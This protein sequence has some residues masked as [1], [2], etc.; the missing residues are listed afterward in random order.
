M[1]TWNK[2]N[3]SI[4]TSDERSALGLIEELGKQTNYNTE[5]VEKVKESNNKKVSHDEMHNLYKIDDQADFTGSWHGL[6]YPTLSDVGLKAKV[7]EIDT[8]VKEFNKHIWSMENMGQDVKEAMTGGSVAVV[9][10]NA[11]THVNI[12]DGEVYGE[13]TNFLNQL[14]K[15]M[16]KGEFLDYYLSGNDERMKLTKSDT[17]KLVALDIKGNTQYSINKTVV[18]IEG[19]DYYFKIATFTKSVEDVLKLLNSGDVYVDG[20]ILKTLTSTT[21]EHLNYKF[22]SGANDKSVFILVA[23]EKEPYTEVIQGNVTGL[24]YDSYDGIYEA[25]ANVFFKGENIKDKTIDIEKM[26]YYETANKNLFDGNFLNFYVSGKNSTGLMVLIQSD[27]YKTLIFDVEPNTEYTLLKDP[28]ESEDGYYYTKLASFIIPKEQ[29]IK[30]NNYTQDGSLGLSYTSSDVTRLV[31]TTGPND[32]SVAITVAKSQIPY[33]EVLKGNYSSYQ[34]FGYT[35]KY[36]SPSLDYYTKDEVNRK[37][38]DLKLNRFIKTGNQMTITMGDSLYIFE[39]KTTSSN[40]LDTYR[41]TKG[42]HKDVLIWEGSDIEA[43]ILEKGASDFVGGVHGYEQYLD[44]NILVDGVKIGNSLDVDVN[45][46]NLTIFVKSYLYRHG[47]TTPVFTRYKKLEFK[48]NELIVSNNMICMVE[49]FI[50]TRYTGSGLYS[51]YK[52]IVNGYTLN[53]LHR[54]VTEGGQTKSNKI[55]E[56]QFFCNGFTI[57]VKAIDGIGEN[58][59]GSVADF[60]SESKPRYKFY[61]DSINSSSGVPLSLNQELIASFSIKIQ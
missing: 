15:N 40:N 29:L 5:E 30:T 17:G 53:T 51:A 16:F 26:R 23:K 19:S 57:N 27:Q 49:D 12:V 18:G 52:S 28:L 34:D 24:L 1:S 33:V 42:T 21:T 31:F 2:K 6:K 3:F 9:G 25:K 41:L 46:N 47:T 7:E 58:Y 11:V 20:A 59:S 4:Y 50:V 61:F 55:K 35:K 44:M 10:R 56:G 43:P 37:I 48:D 54:L 13:K 60:S 39:R 8:T 14:N 32:K 45:F 38:S 36:Y 22:T